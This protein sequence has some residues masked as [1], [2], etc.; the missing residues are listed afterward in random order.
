MKNNIRDLFLIFDLDGT[1]W[2]SSEQLAQSWNI[3]LQST[4]LK[5]TAPYPT[6]QGLLSVLGRTMDEIA[7]ALLPGLDEEERRIVFRKCEEFENT[8]LTTHSGILYPNV[9]ETLSL[10]K[11][12]GYQ[13]AIVSNCQAGYINA[14]YIGTGLRS[15]FCDLEEWGRTKL[16]KSENIRL[17]MKRNGFE[18][19]VYIGDTIKD[20]EAAC[21]A[22][23]PFIHAAYGFGEVPEAE[24]RIHSLKELPALLEDSF[25]CF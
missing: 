6:A 12:Q 8:Y 9:Q 22:E 19:A 10:L 5:G 13:M 17:V 4:P 16:T 15:Y 20:Y 18:K 24:Y 11:D 3:V 7:D 2:D 21:G 1:L 14:F 25:N 23:V